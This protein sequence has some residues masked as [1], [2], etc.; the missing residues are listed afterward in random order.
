MSHIS[1]L[2]RNSN[3][4]FPDFVIIYET[5]DPDNPDEQEKL[6]TELELAFQ[7]QVAH[8]IIEPFTLGKDTA[9]WIKMGNFLHKSC[10]VSG[11]ISLITG[12]CN[13]DLV[14]YTFAGV[15]FLTAG[16][17]A[18]S[19][20]SDPCCKYQIEKNKRRIQDLPLHELSSTSVVVLVRRDDARRKYLQNIVSFSAVCLSAYKVYNMYY[21]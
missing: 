2:R 14:S 15:S 6:E 16:L 11:I 9:R 19:W 4:S 10:V 3:D 20:A 13:K 18:L 12:Y 7:R 5:T 21:L 17:Y 8:I 1:N